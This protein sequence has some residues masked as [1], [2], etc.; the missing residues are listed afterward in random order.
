MKTTI[1][2]EPVNR[3][4]T[5]QSLKD[6]LYIVDDPTYDTHLYTLI[7]SATEWVEQYL[8]RKLITQT[9]YVYLDD[10]PYGDYIELPFGDL[11]SVTAVKYTDSDEVESTF[12]AADYLVD[13]DSV[14]G[15]V[16]LGFGKTWPTDT[17]SPRNP[18]EIEFVTGY[19]AAETAVPKSIKHAI[20]MLC[21]QHWEHR[22]PQ[23]ITNMINIHS[24]DY[25]TKTLLYPHRVWRWTV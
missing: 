7:D 11:Q 13:T 12:A 4:L 21:A 18:I 23:E 19:G 20:K 9:W 3:A 1:K 22:E 6:Q 16:V 25:G 14:P 5:L 17:L 24:L 10:W 8:C 15:R 2:T